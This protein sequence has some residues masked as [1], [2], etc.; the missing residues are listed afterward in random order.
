M[1]S[2]SLAKEEHTFVNYKSHGT[3]LA[4]TN[5]GAQPA[6]VKLSAS[7]LQSLPTV[8][9]FMPTILVTPQIPLAQ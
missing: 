8:L 9:L 4:L 6:P 3:S 7:I 2:T 5:H 1:L